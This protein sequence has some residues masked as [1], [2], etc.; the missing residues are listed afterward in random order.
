MANKAS[1]IHVSTGSGVDIID[2]TPQ[3]E[4]LAARLNNGALLPGSTAALTC[5]SAACRGHFS[6]PLY[7]KG[8]GD[9]PEE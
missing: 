1:R 5:R 4:Q 2:I 7:Q 3:A 9:L 8:L 6:S